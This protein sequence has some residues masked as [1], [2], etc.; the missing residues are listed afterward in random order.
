[1]IQEELFKD[2][3]NNDAFTRANEYGRQYLKDVF[4]RAVFPDKN[5]IKNLSVFEEEL[6]EDFTSS[7]EILEFLNI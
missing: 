5:A 4:S 1:M 6:P 7:E 3:G 2:L